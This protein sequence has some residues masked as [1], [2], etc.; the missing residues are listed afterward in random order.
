MSAGRV[1]SEIPAPYPDTRALGRALQRRILA[2]LNK[3]ERADGTVPV[4]EVRKAAK[5]A[6]VNE[7]TIYN[8][9][10]NGIPETARESFVW[11]DEYDVR[12]AEVRGNVAELHRWLGERG[13]EPLVTRQ[14]LGDIARRRLGKRGLVLLKK[15]E[16]GAR[17]LK[18]RRIIE[19]PQPNLEWQAD[20]FNLGIPVEHPDF[21]SQLV[22]LWACTLTDSCTRYVVGA[23]AGLDKDAGLVLSALAAALR[24]D[25]VYGPYGG[26]PAM[27]LVDNDSPFLADSIVNDFIEV[28]DLRVV[29]CYVG[30]SEGK[31]KVERF[32]GTLKRRWAQLQPDSTEGPGS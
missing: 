4:T 19:I 30:S 32:G 15:G 10:A 17:S 27:I 22:D 6:G 21:P 31:G 1:S 18:L 25:G 16:F 9:R 29:Q 13:V 11:E 8:W 20:F 14:R 23:A 7:R 12:L 26:K 28:L 2:D 3:Q 5:R 24:T